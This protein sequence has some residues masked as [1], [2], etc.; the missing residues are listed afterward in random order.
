MLPKK[1]LLMTAAL[2]ALLVNAGTIAGVYKYQDDKGKWHYTD[3]PPAEVKS[4]SVSTSAKSSNVRNFKQELEE[5][6]KP[7]SEVSRAMLSVVMVETASGNGS[8]FFVTDD[9]YIITNRHVVR[10]TTSSQSEKTET[11]LAQ[12]KQKLEGF[13]RQLDHEKA[14]LE[15]VRMRIAE[16]RE[17]V[18]SGSANTNFRAQYK[19]YVKLYANDK[20]HYDR[21][22]ARYREYESEY[23]SFKSEFGFVS[24]LTNFSRKFTI[25]LK[26]GK[27]ASARLVKISKDHDLALLKLENSSTPHLKLSTRGLPRQGTKVFAIGSPLGISDAL[28]TGIITKSGSKFLFTDTQILPGNSGGPLIDDRGNVLGVNTAVISG[29]RNS[30]NGLGVAIYARRITAEFARELKGKF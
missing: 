10:P 14:R 9:G 8:G 20:K 27:S 26:N 3:K 17:Y 6:F 4:S 30:T 2:L 1:L 18:E 22:R 12:R 11:E 29:G 23:R 21:E 19:R 13:K 16:E 7:T 25:T 15:D 24:S 5:R 28:T